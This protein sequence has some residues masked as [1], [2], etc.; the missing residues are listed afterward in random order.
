[1]SSRNSRGAATA[2][3]GTAI[4]IVAAVIA[5]GTSACDDGGPD[6]D[7]GAG[8]GCDVVDDGGPVGDAPVEVWFPPSSGLM[9]VDSL[10]VRGGS[11][12]PLRIDA[13]RVNGVAATTTSDFAAWE[14][15]IPLAM[16]AN[17]I[18]VESEE[19]DGHVATAPAF[20]ITRTSFDRWQ[21]IRAAALD[22]QAPRALVLEDDGRLS[23]L[24]L[25]TGARDPLSDDWA[26]PGLD[27]VVAGALDVATNRAFV[28]ES[29]FSAYVMS[30]ID[31]ATGTRTII[32]DDSDGSGVQ[33]ESPFALAVDH[34]RGRAVMIDWDPDREPPPEYSPTIITV[35]LATGARTLIAGEGAGSGVEL[36]WPVSLVLEPAG[37]LAYVLDEG[38]GALLS[39]DLETGERK[40]VASGLDIDIYNGFSV[41]NPMEL[42]AANHRILI[43][44]RSSGDL[45]EIDL[46]TGDHTILADL[47]REENLALLDGFMFDGQRYRIFFHVRDEFVTLDL[48]TGERQPI[49]NTRVGAGPPLGDP[50]GITMNQARDRAH[51][52]VTRPPGTKLV[53]GVIKVDLETGN[54]RLCA[55]DERRGSQPDDTIGRAE[56]VALDEDHDRLLVGSS[57]QSR[58]MAVDLETEA[59]TV[60]WDS[61]AAF[62]G[63]NRNITALALYGDALL[64]ATSN[65]DSEA[66]HGLS[67]VGL[68]TGVWRSLSEGIAVLGMAVAHDRGLVYVA[69][70]SNHAITAIDLATGEQF[71]VSELGVPFDFTVFPGM[72]YDHVRNRLMMTNVVLPGGATE[73]LVIDAVTRELT[74]VPLD[75][76]VS[77]S[78]GWQGV[79]LGRGDYSLIV[80]DA[81]LRALLAIDPASGQTVVLSR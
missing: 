55:R 41:G 49:S 37:D 29:P 54:R 36:V 64:V 72:A 80:A 27:R 71:Q 6:R 78:A 23:F 4:A 40:V 26:A 79:A 2:A 74:F 11:A 18:I 38:Q 50:K 66:D 9:A 60:V 73:P 34:E 15:T 24:D 44:S 22:P 52:A 30:E 67:V 28:I 5:W 19:F 81:E 45:L 10:T 56:S 59:R 43:V 16:G 48:T 42:D 20:T 39:I 63:T 35:E 13:V 53:G 65:L 77:N 47:S 8:T 57:E 69:D 75:Q 70:D 7:D 51:I 17:T 61:A 76:S 62:P 68:D 14:A 3:R 58:I 21:R 32:F 46:D 25:E 1:M 33:L 31:L 12:D